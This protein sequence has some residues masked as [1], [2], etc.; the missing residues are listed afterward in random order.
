MDTRSYAIVLE[1]DPDGGFTATVPALPSVVTEGDTV[2]EVLDNA[3]DAVVLCLE[4]LAEQGIDIPESDL[5]ARFERIEVP[6][7]SKAAL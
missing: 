1:P 6:L 3:R 2:E 7:T 4:D 5:G